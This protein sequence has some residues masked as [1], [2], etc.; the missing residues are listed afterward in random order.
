MRLFT[1]VAT[2]DC[3]HSIVTKLESDDRYEERETW[4]D[5]EDKGTRIYVTFGS[6]A[7]FMTEQLCRLGNWLTYSVVLSSRES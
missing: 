3:Y 5:L 1:P 4:F 7:C 2:Y 6:F